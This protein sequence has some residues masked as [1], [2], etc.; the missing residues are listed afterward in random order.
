METLREIIDEAVDRGYKNANN[1][2]KEKALECVEVV[3][4]SKKTF[5]IDD[6]RDLM[7]QFPYETHDKRAW[8]GVIKKANKLNFIEPT[9]ITM[10]NRTGHGTPMQI[11]RSKIY[12]PKETLF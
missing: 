11:W 4:K 3:A 2:W 8:G 5:T 9:G 10:P 7:N 6:V 1:L 12:K